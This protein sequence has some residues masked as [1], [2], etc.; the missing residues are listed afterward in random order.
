MVCC[1][2][3]PIAILPIMPRIRRRLALGLSAG[4]LCGLGGP[5]AAASMPPASSYTVLPAPERYSAGGK[6]E[7][8]EVFSYGCVHCA[9]AAVPVD[10]FRRRLPA[11]VAFKL[12]PAMF[13]RP[14]LVYARGFYVARRFHVVEASHLALFK[15]RWVDH[16]PLDQLPQLAG[17]YAGYGID[18]ARF[19]ALAT[20]RPLWEEMRHDALLAERWGVESTPT[21]IV[22]G[23]YRVSADGN[24]S[25]AGMLEVVQALVRHELSPP[26]HLP[27]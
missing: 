22:N 9:E 7:V 4:L 2:A 3:V 17:F 20:S 13:N 24:H 10:A 21:F 15:A 5:A 8:V 16:Q 14:W 6:V 11:T 18:T 23:R 25:Y 27:H 26:G 1:P 19:M 12:V